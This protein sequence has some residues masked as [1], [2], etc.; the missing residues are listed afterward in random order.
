MVRRVLSSI[1]LDEHPDQKEAALALHKQ[2]Q[3]SLDWRVL[4]HNS[5]HGRVSL[6]SP[7]G[8]EK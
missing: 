6:H 4:A 8:R 1:S 7:G 3:Q 5:G 2:K